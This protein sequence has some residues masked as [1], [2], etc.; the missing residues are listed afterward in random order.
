MNPGQLNT[1][2]KSHGGYSGCDIIWSAV[3]SLTAFKYV[4]Q[5]KFAEGSLSTAV[6]NCNNCFIANVRGGTHWVLI[7]GFAGDNTYYVNDPGFD[8]STYTWFNMLVE[9]K[10]S[11]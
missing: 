6:G 9:S 8:Q 2:L 5:V 11:A 10:Y 1:W 3:N 4:D 7:T